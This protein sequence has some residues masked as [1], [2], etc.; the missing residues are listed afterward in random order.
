MNDSL[1]S[2]IRPVAAP[3]VIENAYSEDQYR[4]LL[5]VVRNHGPWSLILAQH[6][7]SP[8][9]VIATTSG[10]VPE[11]FTPTWDMFLSPVFRGYFGQGGVCL[12]PELEDCYYN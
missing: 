4:R 1:A 5:S 9:E 8:E 6:F 10:S 2:T 3:Q 7:K 12:H 11:G